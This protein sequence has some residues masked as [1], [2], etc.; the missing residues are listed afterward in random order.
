MRGLADDIN[1]LSGF[2][3][4]DTGVRVVEVK[5]NACVAQT[6][7]SG[8]SRVSDKPDVDRRSHKHQNAE[9]KVIRGK[10]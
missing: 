4:F 5:G 8:N 7:A 2:A 1:S 6:I 10:Q 3:G 9:A